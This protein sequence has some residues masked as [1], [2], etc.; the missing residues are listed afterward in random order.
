M[1]STF[2]HDSSTAGLMPG[3]AQRLVAKSQKIK[4]VDATTLMPVSTVNLGPLESASNPVVL[5][6]PRA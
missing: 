6:T 3:I 5:P 1:K 4:A 2:A